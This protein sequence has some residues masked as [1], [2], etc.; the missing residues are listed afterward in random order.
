MK[1]QGDLFKKKKIKTVNN[2]MAVNANLST[3]ES[4]KQ[5][6]HIRIVTESWIQR[7]V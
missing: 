2:K 1:Y 6:K 4:K 3:I 5:T 7:V